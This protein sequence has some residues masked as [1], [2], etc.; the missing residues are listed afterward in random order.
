MQDLILTMIKANQDY[1]NELNFTKSDI[2]NFIKEYNF[3]DEIN[4]CSEMGLIVLWK[5]KYITDEEFAK[6]MDVEF[7][8]DKFW[9]I[10]DSF[11]EIL[12]DKKYSTEIEI[13]S[14]DRDWQGSDYY[15]NCDIE[16]YYWSDYTE[17]T[18]KE[19]IKFCTDKGI[20]I[21]E[22]LMTDENTIL[23]NGD[24]YFKFDEAEEDVKLS[25]LLDEDDLDELKT[26]LNNAI[27]DA[28]DSADRD[29]VYNKIISEF[30][31]SIGFFKRE[32]ATKKDYYGVTKEVEKIHIR[33]DNLNIDDVEDF[34]KE[35][36]GEYN[37]EDEKYGSLLHVLKEMEYFE[38]RTPDYNYISGSI[39]K[40]T[41]NEYTQDKLNW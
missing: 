40:A 11:D 6:Y 4:K 15:D 25:S 21:N 2:D 37:F 22:E 19:I 9:I 7:N 23:K 26:I 16:S 35:D 41:L 38:F 27:C 31:S 39:D 12:S 24:I 14:G 18:L 34:L 28:Q 32:L 30:E 29:E 5:N 8:E 17:D 1:E 3:R 36:Y 20:E 33:L 13:L 10:I